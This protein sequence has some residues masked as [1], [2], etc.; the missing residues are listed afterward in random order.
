MA[1]WYLREDGSI[2]DPDE[3]EVLP[4]GRLRA[5][6]GA[7]VAYGPHGPRSRGVTEDEI[8]EYRTRQAGAMAPQS[9]RT[10]KVR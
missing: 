3:V 4:S 2:C 5:R 8:A 9:Y 1:T 10:R 7:D 6:M